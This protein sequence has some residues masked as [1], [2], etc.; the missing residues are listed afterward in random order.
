PA[1]AEGGRGGRGGGRGGD[2]GIPS[3]STK[4]G[5]TPLLHAARQGYVEAVE[6]L[7]DGGAN[8]NLVSPGDKTSPLLMAVINAQFDTAMTLI[9]HGAD[10][11]LA[12]FNGIAPLWAAVNAEWQPRTRFPQ[13]QEHGQQKATYLDVM[14]ALLKAGADPNARTLQHPWYMVYTGC[15]NGNC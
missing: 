1:N 6:A 15:G 7:L 11:N 4:G 2:D 8:I 3:I 13:P 9:E 14:E 5:L 12:A 10:P